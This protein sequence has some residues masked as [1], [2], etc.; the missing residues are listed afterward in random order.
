MIF[1]W[2]KVDFLDTFF[3]LFCISRWKKYFLSRKK[4]NFSLKKKKSISFAFRCLRVIKIKMEIEIKLSI[5]IQG[6]PKK[7]LRWKSDEESTFKKNRFLFFFLPRTVFRLWVAALQS[8]FRKSFLF[9]PYLTEQI[10]RNTLVFH[11]P[12]MSDLGL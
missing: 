8:I 7:T 10:L 6:V 9:K 2:Q 3:C 1:F 5:W 4:Y 11:L 12:Q